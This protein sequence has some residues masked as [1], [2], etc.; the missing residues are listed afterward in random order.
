MALTDLQTVAEYTLAA[1]TPVAKTFVLASAQFAA[2]V[3]SNTGATNAIGTTSIE[4]SV[5][6]TVFAASGITVASI[7]HDASAF[8]PLIA[9]G[10]LHSVRVT[11]TSASGS[12][13]AL[14]L[15]FVCP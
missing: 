11:L 6:G 13:A 7:A 12:T 3:I 14:A 5:D 8:V 4:F 1:A 2:L 15:R 9:Y 10:P